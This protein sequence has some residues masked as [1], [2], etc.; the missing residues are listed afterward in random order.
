MAGPIAEEFIRLIY[1]ENFWGDAELS[2]AFQDW[3]SEH[4]EL[5]DWAPLAGI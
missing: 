3:L 2:E 4:V 1:L 5:P